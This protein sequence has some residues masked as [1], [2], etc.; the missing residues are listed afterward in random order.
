MSKIFISKWQNNAWVDVETLMG[1]ADAAFARITQLAGDGN[2]YKAETRKVNEI[3]PDPV[4]IFPVT[5]DE[6]D[7]NIT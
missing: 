3:P 6:A 7:E 1:E 5:E 2:R 4:L